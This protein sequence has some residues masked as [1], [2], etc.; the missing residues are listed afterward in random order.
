MT[1]FGEEETV[2]GARSPLPSSTRGRLVGP[3]AK[4]SKK[5]LQLY[6]H[7]RTW[8]LDLI[9][10]RLESIYDVSTIGL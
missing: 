2:E 10:A 5:Y 8:Q 6:A 4:L 9:S 3:S 7:V 1:K